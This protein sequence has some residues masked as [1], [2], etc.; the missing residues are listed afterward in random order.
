MLYDKFLS[1]VDQI[2]HQLGG[3]NKLLDVIAEKV[4]AKTIVKAACGCGSCLYIGSGWGRCV[5]D[6]FGCPTYR[7]QFWTYIC[8]CGGVI[9]E[10]TCQDQPHCCVG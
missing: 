7:V 8:N 4:I 3:V 10:I 6:P 5:L 2:T 1:N 9:K